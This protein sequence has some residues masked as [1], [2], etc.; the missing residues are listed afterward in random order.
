MFQ[1]KFEFTALCALGRKVTSKSH[2]FKLNI[3]TYMFQERR[4]RPVYY[5]LNNINTLEEPG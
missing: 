5:F 4:N 2:T 1:T 3:L